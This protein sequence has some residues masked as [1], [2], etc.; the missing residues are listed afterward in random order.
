MI[1][2]F[3]TKDISYY[4]AAVSSFQNHFVIRYDEAGWHNSGE[5]TY[6][7]LSVVSSEPG[8]AETQ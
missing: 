2:I 5:V 8:T 1:T 7:V 3:N 4:T 6:I